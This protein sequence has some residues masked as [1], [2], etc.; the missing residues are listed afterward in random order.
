MWK[1]YFCVF[2]V[3]HCSAFAKVEEGVVVELKEDDVTGFMA[4]YCPKHK[5]GLMTSGRG[6]I[7][8]NRER[9][10][11]PLKREGERG[12]GKWKRISWDE[13]L[14]TIAKKLLE[15]KEKYGPESVGIVLN[16]PKGLEFA[17]AQRFATA[18]G[19]PNV[20]SPGTY[21]GI[22]TVQ[23]SYYTFGSPYI[24]ARRPIGYYYPKVLIIW[25]SNPV[26]TG[27]TFNA[28]FRKDIHFAIDRGCMVVVVDQRNID[29]DPDT[30]KR[31]SDV[32]YWLKPRPASDGVLA[33]GMIKVIIEEELYDKDYIEKWTVGFD[34]LQEHVKTFTL[35]EVEKLTW[36]P[37]EQIKEVARL[38]AVN[39]PGVIGWGNGL[40]QSIT[41]FQTCRAIAILRGITGNVNTPNGGEV[42]HE[43]APFTRPGR[44]MFSG[45]LK[46]RLKEYPRSP[47]RTIGSE[48]KIA[49][50]SAYVPTQLLVKS[51]LEG[52]PYP[53]RVALLILTNPLVSYPDSNAVREALMKLD[54]IA[55]ADIFH[56]PTTA[57]A[58]I[59]LPAATFLEHEDLGYWPYWYGNIRVYPKLVD[60]PGEA[61]PDSK[62]INELAKRVGL[63]EYFFNHEDEALD[64]MLQPLN[65][66]YKEF[67]E[68]VG[69]IYPKSLYNPYE[70]I[71]Y[72]TPSGKV[73][74]YSKQLEELGI[75][76]M[77]T[78]DE[79]A[80]SVSAPFE[81]GEEYPL[82]LTNGKSEVF[83]LTG[84]RNLRK[85]RSVE[86][87]PIVLL[88]PQTAEKYGLNDG[89]WIYIETRKGRI[90][91]RLMVD[92]TVDPRVVIAAFGWWGESN[93]N[94]LTDS[95]PPYDPA[96]GAPQLK[97]IPC[98][99]YKT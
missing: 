86:R 83:I 42:D 12:E 7:L 95:N 58:D 27:G 79:L 3:S 9:L 48:F 17:F 69:A 72:R 78:F 80:K 66:T 40:E 11:Y 87:D 15:A 74:I 59:L 68:K 31:A 5:G 55:V 36:I 77:P 4:N 65:L 88:N 96:T 38:Y 46:E 19:T 51:V 21:C 85:L 2:C 14:D 53:I 56:T 47:E 99:V 28:M 24:L 23:A 61:W 44:F 35:D 26:H 33:M 49:M 84:F 34:K 16:E 50:R 43:P 97:G 91:Q 22:A 29:V 89:E 1:Q 18:F 76:P 41:S 82:L 90:K 25:G 52:K 67:K 70:V 45:K 60:P 20:F 37:K 81:P 6:G 8:N 75:A 71:G 64:F 93:L 54:F 57:Y 63:G 13:A 98:K 92:P 10:R 73:E 62:I 94:I 32:E 30:G 39:K